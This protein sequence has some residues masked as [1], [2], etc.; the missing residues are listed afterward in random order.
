MQRVRAG[1]TGLAAIFLM[2][3]I[4]AAGLRPGRSAGHPASGETLAMLGVAP[5][6]EAARK[7]APPGRALPVARPAPP[8]S[9]TP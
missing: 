5:G 7:T 8:V 4:A 3:L 9:T 1:L 6:A 2:V